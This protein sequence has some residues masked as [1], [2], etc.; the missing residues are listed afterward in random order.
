MIEGAWILSRATKSDTI[1]QQTF[2]IDEKNPER[3]EG[4][5]LLGKALVRSSSLTIIP[6]KM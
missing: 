1:D 3:K 2:M 5:P 6:P 4:K